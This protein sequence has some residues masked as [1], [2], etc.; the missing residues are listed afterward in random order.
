MS[1]NGGDKWSALNFGHYTTE[2]RALIPTKQEV[3]WAP[4]PVCT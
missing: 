1:P 2:E 3:G 4:E